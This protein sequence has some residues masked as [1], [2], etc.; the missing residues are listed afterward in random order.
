M[1][2]ANGPSGMNDRRAECWAAGVRSWLQNTCARG[3]YTLLERNA[4]TPYGEIDLV[5]Y[6]PGSPSDGRAL[7][8]VEVK[9]RRSMLWPT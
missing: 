4:R 2:E 1:I 6:Q 5:A 8:F 9:T 3:G 7:I